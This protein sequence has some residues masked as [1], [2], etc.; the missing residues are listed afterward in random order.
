MYTGHFPEKKNTLISPGFVM[1]NVSFGLL[2]IHWSF[3]RKKKT[4]SKLYRPY[5]LMWFF[6][7]RTF[8]MIKKRESSDESLWIFWMILAIKVHSRSTVNARSSVVYH[9]HHISRPFFLKFIIAFLFAIFSSFS[10][11]LDHMGVKCF[12]RQSSSESTHQS[13][14]QKLMY[15]ATSRRVLFKS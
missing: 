14:S 11:T 12:K 10:L 8:W 1:L 15:T 9:I 2:S 13:H 5:N 7:I 3:S 6:F 4:F